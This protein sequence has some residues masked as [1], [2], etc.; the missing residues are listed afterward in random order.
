MREGGARGGS[1]G[2]N[3]R[4]RGRANREGSNAREEDERRPASMLGGECRRER[5]RGPLQGPGDRQLAKTQFHQCRRMDRRT[6]GCRDDARSYTSARF[7]RQRATSEF[8]NL[9][10]T[11]REERAP[12]GPRARLARWIGTSAGCSRRCGRAA[13]RTRDRRLVRTRRSPRI[14]PRPRRP[15]PMDMTR[16]RRGIPPSRD[17][18]RRRHLPRRMRSEPHRQHPR[19]SPRPRPRRETPLRPRPNP[20]AIPVPFADR[21]PSRTRRRLRRRRPSRRL[22][23]RRPSR[24]LCIR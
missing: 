8:G 17:P 21:R 2:P 7:S 6:R 15:E 16:P 22:P 19:S 23:R 3:A 24:N 1:N 10:T 13:C 11:M 20:R 12:L 18:R 9:T 5:P 4:S 14:L